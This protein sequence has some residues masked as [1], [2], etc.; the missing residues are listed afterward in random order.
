VVQISDSAG[1]DG[2][3]RMSSGGDALID[4]I[5][6]FLGRASV[7]EL[8]LAVLFASAA[9]GLAETFVSGVVLAPITHGPGN[10]S[11]WG[12]LTL[13]VDGRAIDFSYVLGSALTV[14]L[15]CL[16]AVPLIR[17]SELALWDDRDLRE[18]PYCLSEIPRDAPVCS[19]C[20]RDMA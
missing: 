5:K 13:A 12:E 10:H 11:S 2:L 20:T 14:V 6:E 7:L 1:G 8:F 9:I 4:D 15:V 17:R 3:P 19:Y 18:C 16:L